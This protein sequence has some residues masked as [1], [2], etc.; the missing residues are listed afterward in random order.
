LAAHLGVEFGKD[1][2]DVP[3]TIER[4]RGNLILKTK[5]QDLKV[6]TVTPVGGNKY[7]FDCED[8]QSRQSEVLTVGC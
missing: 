2:Q 7:V 3:V 6:I 4:A 5:G 8:L 1:K